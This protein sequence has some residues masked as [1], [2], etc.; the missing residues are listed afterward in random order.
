MDILAL[1][2]AVILGVGVGRFANIMLGHDD[3]NLIENGILG[4]VGI[5]IY[6]V[7]VWLLALLDIAV[8]NVFFIHLAGA[9]ICA[10]LA[11]VVAEVVR[12]R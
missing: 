5:V 12:G 10:F 7:G 1:I 8:P 2:F 9:S 4:V 6:S 3:G 11:V